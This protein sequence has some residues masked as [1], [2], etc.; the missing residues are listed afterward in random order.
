MN[1]HEPSPGS[2][3]FA[4]SFRFTCEPVRFCSV[5]PVYSHP[6]RPLVPLCALPSAVIPRE[7]P[8][9]FFANKKDLPKAM[10]PNEIAEELRISE[11]CGDRRW[12]IV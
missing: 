7:T 8:F 3:H 2:V 5:L 9:L 1:V 4:V 6:S 12:N 10:S 11:L